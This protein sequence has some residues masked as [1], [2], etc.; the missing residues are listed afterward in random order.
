MAKKRKS[1]VVARKAKTC[2]KGRKMTTS[3]EAITAISDMLYSLLDKAA[4]RSKTKRRST[5]K[6]QDLG[7]IIIKTKKP[8]KSPYFGPMSIQDLGKG[9]FVVTAKKSRKSPYFGPMSVRDLGEGKF[10][11]T[12]KSP[13]PGPMLRGSCLGSKKHVKR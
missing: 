4:E 12:T 5:I 9:K 11:V 3:S 8:R 7:E 6:A 13:Y 2:F 1:L 10:V